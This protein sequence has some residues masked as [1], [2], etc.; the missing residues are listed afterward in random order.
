[1]NPNDLT[2][3]EGVRSQKISTAIAA[4]RGYIMRERL[5]DAGRQAIERGLERRENVERVLASLDDDVE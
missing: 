5:I 3:Y 1:M 2:T 4:C